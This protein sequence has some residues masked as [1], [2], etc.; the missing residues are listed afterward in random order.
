M[1]CA[2]SWGACQGPPRPARAEAGPAWCTDPVQEWGCKVRLWEE[3]H[4]LR[5]LGGGEGPHLKAAGKGAPCWAPV[6]VFSVLEKQTTLEGVRG[7]ALSKPPLLYALSLSKKS[8]RGG[9]ENSYSKMGKD[10]RSHNY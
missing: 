8:G 2:R 3:E 7:G 10:L 1:G 9:N 6:A 5:V 4:W